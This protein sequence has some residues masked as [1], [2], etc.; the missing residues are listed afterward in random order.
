MDFYYTVT[1]IIN[2]QNYFYKFYNKIYFDI[3]LEVHL[4]SNLYWSFCLPMQMLLI[5]WLLSL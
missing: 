4:S 1:Q 3:V 2:L 5:L